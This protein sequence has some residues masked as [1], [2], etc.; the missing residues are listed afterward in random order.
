MEALK[1]SDTSVWHG[2]GVAVRYLGEQRRV[3]ED[4][5]LSQRV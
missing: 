1:V 4:G 5:V 2:K 3:G